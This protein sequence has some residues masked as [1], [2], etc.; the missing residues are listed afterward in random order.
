MEGDQYLIFAVN[1]SG[2]RGVNGLQPKRESY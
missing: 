2:I 1:I